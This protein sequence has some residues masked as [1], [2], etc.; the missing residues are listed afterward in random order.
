MPDFKFGDIV[1]YRG[2]KHHDEPLM[3]VA[4]CS[5][6]G[7]NN[8]LIDLLDLTNTY[9]MDNRDFAHKSGEMWQK[10]RHISPWVVFAK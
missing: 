2:A 7:T 6:M 1:C 10:C 9:L 5:H 4:P 8:S 3:Y